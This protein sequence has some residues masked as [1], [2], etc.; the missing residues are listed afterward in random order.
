MNDRP[1]FVLDGD[2]SPLRAGPD[3]DAGRAGRRALHP[4]PVLPPRVQAARQLQAVHGQGRTAAPSPRAPRAP[5]PAS[6]SR[7]TPP[8]S[9]TLR[10]TLVQML[11][12]EGN[13]FCPSCEKS[14]NCQLQAL[15]LRSRHD[16]GAL[17]TTCSRTGRWTPRT[18][19]SCSTSTAASCASCACAP[20]ATSTA[21]TCS[22]SPGRG[23]GKHLIVNCR[24]GPAGA[25]P[26]SRWPTRPST[27]ARS[28]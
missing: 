9:T 24:L 1:T 12:V 21:R 17:S 3:R 10:R 15:G 20:R 6:R 7:A 28:A 25:T 11:F 26:T 18:P 27:C 22:R 4:A 13:H 16:D 19:T 23:I 14:G 5:R 8:N 2:R